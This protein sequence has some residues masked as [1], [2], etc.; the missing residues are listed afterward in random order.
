MLRPA[1]VDHHPAVRRGIAEIL[2]GERDI[3]PVGSA[4]DRRELWPLLYRADPDVLLVGQPRGDDPLVLALQVRGRFPGVRVVVYA[5][6]DEVLVPAAF[7]G[8]HGVVR[9][10]AEARELLETVRAVGCGARVLPQLTPLVQRRAAARLAP[11]DRAIL[12]M[13]LA[14]T[15][16]RDIA[17]TVGM[18]PAQLAGRNAAIVAA[19][20]GR[21]D[22]GGPESPVAGVEFFAA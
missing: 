17:T 12:A 21:G 14:G 19:L 18:S 11:R 20:R 2:R 16:S 1:I 15:T 5:D 10:E 3:A 9:R 22:G 4:A 8:V 7:A 13:R 6:G